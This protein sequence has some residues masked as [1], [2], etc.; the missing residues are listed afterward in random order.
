MAKAEDNGIAHNA[1][2]EVSFYHKMLSQELP[3][4][5]VSWHEAR[6]S[7]TLRVQ[8]DEKLRSHGYNPIITG[9]H[10]TDVFKGHDWE[11]MFKKPYESIDDFRTCCYLMYR[12]LANFGYTSD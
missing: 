3:C 1:Y 6:Q 12:H 10:M 9:D 2:D 11:V 5:D 4:D 8:Y 7:Q